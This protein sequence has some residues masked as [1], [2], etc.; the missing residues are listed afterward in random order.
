[1]NRGGAPWRMSLG[2]RCQL[3]WLPGSRLNLMPDFCELS[4]S[5]ACPN[6][7]RGL[8][9]NP[10]GIVRFQ[11]GA[12]PRHYQIGDNVSWIQDSEGVASPPFTIVWRSSRLG[13]SRVPEYNCG[14]PDFDNLYVFDTDPNVSDWGCSSCGMVFEGLA[15]RI[16]EGRFVDVRAIQDSKREIGILRGIADII[17]CEADGTW[18]P[19]TDWADH[20]L[21]DAGEPSL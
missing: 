20:P 4:C 16:V 5:P 11:W 2:G 18:T 13:R 15:V 7:G 9:P 12:V 17:V 6:C 1:M 19:R 10:C 3:G 8:A 21:V 14:T